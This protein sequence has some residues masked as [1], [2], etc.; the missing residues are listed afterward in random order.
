MVPTWRIAS[1]TGGV[2]RC[3]DF[4]GLTIDNFGLAQ[5]AN[6][7]QSRNARHYHPGG[8]VRNQVHTPTSTPN[9]STEIWLVEVEVVWGARQTAT[10]SSCGND[11]RFVAR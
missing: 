4:A 6:R 5:E 2:K 1:P 10:A 8:H 3:Q 9:R 11:V 7:P